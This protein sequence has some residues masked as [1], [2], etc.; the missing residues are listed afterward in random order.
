LVFIALLVWS[1]DALAQSPGFKANTQKYR[2]K[3]PAGAKGRAGGATMAARMLYAKDG[4]TLLEA[5]TGEFD[6]PTSPTGDF[7]RVKAIA[8]DSNGVEMFTFNNQVAGGSYFQQAL[9]GLSPG[10]PFAVQG[11]V[12]T[13]ARKNTPIT[14][15]TSVQKRPDLAAQRIIVPS[16]VPTNIPVQIVAV[17]AELNGYIGARTDCVLYADDVE[18]DRSSSIWVDSGDSVSCAFSPTFAT[19]G[20]VTLKVSAQTVTPGDWD[21][22]NNTLERQVEVS[23]LTPEF[24]LAYAEVVVADVDNT[25]FQQLGRY[26]NSTTTAGNDWF[27][28]ETVD[29]N[30]D[31]FVYSAAA[32]GITYVP[33]QITAAATDGIGSWLLERPVPGCFDYA[34]G[35]VN[36]RTYYTYVTGCGN[37]YVEVGSYAGTVTYASRLVTRTFKVVDNSVQYDAPAQYV[38]NNVSTEVG[39][40][41]NLLKGDAWTIDVAVTAGP[42]IFKAPVSVL[43]N[44][45]SDTGETDPVVCENTPTSSVC[46]ASS[47]RI[48]YR[49]GSATVTRPQP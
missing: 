4:T 43:L 35:R 20:P 25:T 31:G 37:L 26:V 46:S 33:T 36:G 42:F 19:L 44:E 11:H 34:V 39:V 3:N 2:E 47:W 28:E 29:R 6:A 41:E 17:I 23:D 16:R 18:I 8:Y 40:G 12:R 32:L 48:A 14:I 38:Y 10:Q 7:T 5:T 24:D 22:A 15:T 49:S 21:A 13:T 9:S 27:Y 1:S 30:A 45:V